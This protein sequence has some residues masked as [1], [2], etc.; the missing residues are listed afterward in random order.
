METYVV[1]KIL[2]LFSH[3]SLRLYMYL[4]TK[5]LYYLLNLNVRKMSFTTVTSS[6]DTFFFY[7]QSFQKVIFPMICFLLNNIYTTELILPE[8]ISNSPPDQKL[9]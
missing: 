7:K 4:Q 1:V 3:L 8:R 6:S 5:I 9:G 2:S